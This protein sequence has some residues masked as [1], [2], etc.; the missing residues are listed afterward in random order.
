MYMKF[1]FNHLEIC[2]NESCHS[3]S[4]ILRENIFL[5]LL[6]LAS[7]ADKIYEIT[8]SGYPLMVSTEGL[9]ALFL[10]SLDQYSALQLADDMMWLNYA[11][12]YLVYKGFLMDK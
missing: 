1:L 10:L 12:T 5:L 3:R 7:M 4:F 11:Y 9:R 6:S 8:H 2:L